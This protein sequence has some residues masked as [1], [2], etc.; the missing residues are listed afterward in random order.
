MPAR[1]K[2]KAQ[3][4]ENGLVLLVLIIIIVLAFV[5][6]SFSGISISQVHIDQSKSTMLA[7]KQAKQAVI[8]YAVTYSDRISSAPVKN[9]YGLLPNAET[10]L[11][12][13]YGTMAG[14][15]GPKNTNVIGWLPWRSLGLPV[16]KDES[17]TCLFYAISGTYK[18]GSNTQ[19]DMINEDSIGMFQIVD[20]AGK[21][22]KGSADQDRVVAVVIAPGEALPGQA[23]NPLET[24]SNCG[25]DYSNVSAYLDDAGVANNSTVSALEDTVDKFIHAT[26]TSKKEAV[27]YNDKFLTIT[28]DEIWD[29]IIARDDFKNDMASLAEALAKCVANYANH[30]LNNAR[31]LPWATKINLG[32]SLS[33]RDNINY[34]D[35]P[36][37]DGYSGRYPF[38]VGSSNDAI[39]PVNMVEDSLFEIPGLCGDGDLGNDWKDAPM[40]LADNSSKY[41]QLWNNWKDHFFYMISGSY[42]PANTDDEKTCKD[43]GTSCI[44]INTTKHAGAVIFSGSRLAGATRTNKTDLAEYLEDG[45]S[46]VFIDEQADKI[47][48]KSYVYTSPQTDTVNDVMYC[49]RDQAKGEP[50]DV[51]ECP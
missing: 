28:R 43:A 40:N 41:R 13:F 36:A 31:R 47:G 32:E 16:L 34:D 17:G 18:V 42:K 30:A 24:S 15:A 45:K 44:E 22:I 6:Y 50:L 14:N 51:V 38:D 48:D 39:D 5:T 21:V 4:K 46:G 27:P 7:L 10:F 49:I 29:A 1:K 11:N 26:E 33:Y 8:N 25:D 19:A 37:T 2:Y 12:G 35:D 3:K 23:R 9:E 20:A